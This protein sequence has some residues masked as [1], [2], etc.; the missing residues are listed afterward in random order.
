MART[1][2]ARHLMLTHLWPSLDPVASVEEGSDA[3]GRA[4]VLAAPHLTTHI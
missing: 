3:F 2:K 1:A 4:V